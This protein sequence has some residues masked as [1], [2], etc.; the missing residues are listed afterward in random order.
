MPSHRKG[1]T[2][3]RPRL[4]FYRKLLTTCSLRDDFGKAP[5]TSRGFRK[6]PNF[7]P[8]VR[9]PARG[10]GRWAR[11][12]GPRLKRHGPTGR[13]NLAQGRAQRCPGGRRAPPPRPACLAG[14]DPGR[15]CASASPFGRG[16]F[17]ASISQGIARSAQP[18]GWN[19]GALQ[20]P[21]GSSRKAEKD[22]LRRMRVQLKA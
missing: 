11:N 7:K 6:P 3:C 21:A 17:P 16:H 20:A 1:M 10:V 5:G 22:E 4:T 15:G 13:E 14:R 8:E 9:V 18:L 2:P 19:L 12:I